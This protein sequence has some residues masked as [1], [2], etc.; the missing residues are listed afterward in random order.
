MCPIILIQFTGQLY[1][2]HREIVAY[3][4]AGELNE[5]TLVGSVW[6]PIHSI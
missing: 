5:P 2:Q 3:I 4:G 6:N 1:M